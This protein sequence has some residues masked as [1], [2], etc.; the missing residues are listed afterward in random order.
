MKSISWTIVAGL[1]ALLWTAIAT[2][3]GVPKITAEERQAVVSTLVHSL[4]HRYVLAEKGA[5]IAQEIA[6]RSEDGEF[7]TS[8]DPQTLARTLSKT[9]WQVSQD[10]H[11]RVF[12]DGP[13]AARQPADSSGANQ[14]TP[15][16]YE[17][18]LRPDG[19]GVLEVRKLTGPRQDL[20][21]AM[22][23]VAEAEALII[24]LRTCPG[25]EMGMPAV[26][27]SY[28]FDEPAL[29]LYYESRDGE[30][31]PIYT[32]RLPEGSPSF[33]GKPIYVAISS[34]T[35][36]GCEEMAFDLKHHDKAI[37]VGEKTAGAGL[38]SRTGTTD[39]GH[40]FEAFIPDTKPVHPHFEGGFEGV[41]VAPDIATPA[42]QAI[43]TARLSALSA[44]LSS[45]RDGAARENLRGL[46]LEAALEREQAQR[47]RVRTARSF[48]PYLGKY[49]G[50]RE[51]Q[52][53]AG[54]LY[55]QA[56]DGLYRS[57]LSATKEGDF[58]L[59]GTRSQ[60]LRFER[61]E[62]GRVI[63]LKISEPGGTKW[64]DLVPK[65]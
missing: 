56:G 26:L 14:E 33:D 27:A 62:Q 17:A 44:L 2:A 49:E 39:L 22:D 63:G 38:G 16:P 52:L 31:D 8:D 65:L 55:Y 3:E 21:A 9:L 24:D 11:L 46:F 30:R 59:A 13:V 20:A 4:Q 50:E 41:G 34:R 37:L 54:R 28:L 19:L 42:S 32:E 51:I 36:S 61:N 60:R 48:A 12:Y 23:E 47:Q 29:L 45:P 35:G 18:H 40:G 43:T 1:V 10:L 25:G 6:R 5:A 7:S 57:E 64:R 58:S 15:R 53:T